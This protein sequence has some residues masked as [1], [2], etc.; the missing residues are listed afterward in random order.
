MSASVIAV[1]FEE[2]AHEPFRRVDS[3]QAF[4][5]ALRARP[6]EWALL[7]KYST[8]GL[9]RQSAYEV[10]NALRPKDQPFTPAG[11]FEAEARTMLGEHRVYVRYV[12]GDVR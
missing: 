5:D 3:R 4:A 1:R 7:G 9:A 8:G 12:G 11:T 2:P 6:N 10:R